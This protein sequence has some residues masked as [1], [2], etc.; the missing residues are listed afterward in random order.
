MLIERNVPDVGVVQ[1]ER[2]LDEPVALGVQFDADG[3]DQRVQLGIRVTAEV[4]VAG[5]L[6]AYAVRNGEE[7]DPRIVGGGENPQQLEAGVALL[8]LRDVPHAHNR[9]LSPWVRAFVDWIASVLAGGCAGNF[10]DSSRLQ[11][12]PVPDALIAIIDGRP[13]SA[14]EL[15]ISAPPASTGDAAWNGA[16]P[17]SALP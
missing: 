4:P 1:D 5:P 10:L 7:R 13:I 11:S 6:L 12:T 14:C 2:L 15:H 16:R 17:A 3:V 8:D 9:H